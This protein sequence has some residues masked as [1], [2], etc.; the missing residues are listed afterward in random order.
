MKLIFVIL[1]LITT[2]TFNAIAGEQKG[3]V[4]ALYARVSDGLHLVSLKLKDGLTERILII[5]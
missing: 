5:L 2:F 4:K 3:K 1:M